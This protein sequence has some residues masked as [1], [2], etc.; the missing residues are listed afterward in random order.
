MSY[1]Q[2]ASEHRAPTSQQPHPDTALLN[3][4]PKI[5]TDVTLPDG[6]S[7][8]VTIAPADYKLHPKVRPLSVVLSIVNI[9][10]GCC[11]SN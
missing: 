7:E 3:T 9:N 5:D 11:A 2:V 8:K 6:S 10:R 1:A 4:A